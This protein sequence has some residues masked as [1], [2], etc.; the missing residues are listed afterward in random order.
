MFSSIQELSNA[1]SVKQLNCLAPSVSAFL[2]SHYKGEGMKHFIFIFHH[3]L[4]KHIMKRSERK[5]GMKR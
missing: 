4:I 1:S 5:Q 2:L 3:S